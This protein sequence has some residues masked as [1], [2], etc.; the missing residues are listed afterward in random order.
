MYKFARTKQVK[1]AMRNFHSKNQPYQI[2]TT[3]YLWSTLFLL[4]VLVNTN[5]AHID[6]DDVETSWLKNITVH[7]FPNG[8]IHSSKLSLIIT[9]LALADIEDGVQIKPTFSKSHCISN[10]T[11]LFVTNS[12]A[13]LS[14]I[15]VSLNNFNFKEHPEAYLCIKTKYDH[16]FQHMG[17]K[18]KFPK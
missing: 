6:F 11:E 12:A 4:I 7:V 15:I 8:N 18:S 14:G 5:A 3:K 16:G 10:E 9:G 17:Y 13:T 2:R 1:V